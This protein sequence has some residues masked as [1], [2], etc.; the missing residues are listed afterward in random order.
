MNY[1]TFTN[2]NGSISTIP[3]EDTPLE[4]S[5][6]TRIEYDTVKRLVYNHFRLNI[7]AITTN[8]RDTSF[9]YALFVDKGDGKLNR[10]KVKTLRA[11]ICGILDCLK[12]F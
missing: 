12:S 5:A 9:D 10:D 1:Y 11:Y 8:A 3:T 4:L 2:A 6:R 7:T